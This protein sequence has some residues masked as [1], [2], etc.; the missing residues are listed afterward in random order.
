VKCDDT[1]N[2]PSVADLGQ[3][4][5]EVGVAPSIP[6]EFVVFRIGRTENTLQV[7]E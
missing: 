6:A 7:T 5:A 4:V 3:V 2:P 1:N